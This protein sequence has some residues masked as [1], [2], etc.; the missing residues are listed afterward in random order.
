[1]QGA[2]TAEWR[3][4]IGRNA[5][6]YMKVF[7]RIERKGGGWVPAWNAAAFFHSTGWFCYRRM[8]GYAVLNLLAWPLLILG[9]V[10]FASLLKSDGNLDFAFSM[11]F[12]AYGVVV[13][14]LV[15][16]FADSL[17]FRSLRKGFERARGPSVE[18]ELRGPSGW[19]TL[20]ALAFVLA[21][22]LLIGAMAQTLYADYGVE[23][24]KVSEAL[25]LAITV[26]TD[27]DGFYRQEK[28][29]PTETEAAKFRYQPQ[30]AETRRVN[31]VSY[32]S[33]AQLIVITMRDPFPGK[34]FALHVE[35]RDGNPVWT[36]RSI[37]LDRK[38]L[39]AA[40]RD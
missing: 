8:Y 35:I 27:I 32:D 37:D 11:L 28:R 13:L 5:D 31:S 16:V 39:P 40:C 6:R 15:P 22:L 29:L 12:I 1:M 17:Y 23:R 18:S 30:P 34:R 9:C 33:S 21:G 10:W 2:E 38:Q 26:R 36:C 14:I 24:A 7:D 25:I 19:T 20:G 3:R 4:A